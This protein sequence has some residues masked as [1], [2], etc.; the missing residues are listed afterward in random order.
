LYIVNK[1][2]CCYFCK[3]KQKI[4]RIART[5]PPDPLIRTEESV[6]R[7]KARDVQER[8]RDVLAALTAMEQEV[9][10]LMCRMALKNNQ[11]A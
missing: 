7:N 4:I 5:P 2:C 8:D 11:P 3:K 9:L 10:G 6:R 1:S